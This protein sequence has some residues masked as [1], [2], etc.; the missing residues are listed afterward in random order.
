M[1]KVCLISILIFFI[2]CKKDEISSPSNIDPNS[3]YPT[4]IYKLSNSEFDSL[5]VQFKNRLQGTIYTANLDSFGLLGDYYKWPKGTSLIPDTL[6]AVTLTKTAFL[7]LNDFSNVSDTS[8]LIVEG[9]IDFVGWRT[10]IFKYQIYQGLEVWGTNITG[11]VT[12]DSIYLSGHHYKD[13]F[14]PQQNLISKDSIKSLL[15]GKEI[16]YSCD[17]VGKFIVDDSSININTIEQCIYPLIK[18]NSIELRVA[19]KVPIT[20]FYSQYVMWDY[21]V[22]VLTGEEIDVLQLFG[23]ASGKIVSVKKGYYFR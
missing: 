2:S 21:F 16:Y 10:I 22:D 8:N 13:I 23:C 7:K 6:Q 14:I 17:A 4:T 9:I 15:I 11:M 18:N 19:W 3:S 12:N 5:K 1:K 20:P